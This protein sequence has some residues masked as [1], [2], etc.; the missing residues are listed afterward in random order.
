MMKFID[1]T[2][3]HSDL[4]D[5]GVIVLDV[6]LRGAWETSYLTQLKILFPK[7]YRQYK[8]IC[9]NP[10]HIV[11][12]SVVILEEDG[13]KFALIF[14]KRSIKGDMIA[15]GN[16]FESA[17]KSMFNIIP[18]DVNFYSPLLGRDDKVIGTFMNVI[19]KYTVL[20]ERNWFIYRRFDA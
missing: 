2:F 15:M 5:A 6:S 13:Y 18:K 16:H 12:G 17:V 19:R 3:L 7:T 10:N 14:T 1:E 20:E 8:G 4:N 11:P 9:R